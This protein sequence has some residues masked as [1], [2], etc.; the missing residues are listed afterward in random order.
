MKDLTLIGFTGLAGSGKTTAA[1]ILLNEHGFHPVSFA[2]PLKAMARAFGLSD[3]EL[4][5]DLKEVPS[6]HLCGKTPRQFMQFLGT[7][8]GRQLIGDDLWL[9]AFRCEVQKLRRDG[10][11]RLAVDDVR[12]E[13]EAALIREMGGRVIRIDRPGAGSASGAGHAS[14]GGVTRVD[15]VISNGGDLEVFAA[16]CRLIFNGEP[17][18]S[19]KCSLRE[20]SVAFDLNASD[21]TYCDKL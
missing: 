21:C 19:C 13:N 6:I 15:T 17:F 10:W 7:E 12:F 18:T 9:R 11:P 14:E 1:Q 2:G 16:R 4:S 20:G 8:F 3:R 5:G